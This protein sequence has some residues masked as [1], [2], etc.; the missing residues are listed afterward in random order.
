MCALVAQWL[1]QR[2]Q[3]LK[4][5][6]GKIRVMNFRVT[7]KAEKLALPGFFEKCLPGG[8]GATSQVERK[9]LD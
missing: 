2:T 4:T 5:L 7:V 9:G 8:I 1:E 6:S 3:S